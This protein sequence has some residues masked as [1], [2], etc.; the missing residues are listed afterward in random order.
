MNEEA[1]KTRTE[2]LL[3]QLNDDFGPNDGSNF[4]LMG[5]LRDEQEQLDPPAPAP[6]EPVEAPEAPKED[7]ELAYHALNSSIQDLKRT[8]QQ[9][10]D[11]QSQV[12]Q[13]LSR[14]QQTTP[15]ENYD[16]TQLASYGDLM[17]IR[18]QLSQQQ[19]QLAQQQ[20]QLAAQTAWERAN[21][22]YER[23]ASKHGDFS[24]HMN[25]EQ[26]GQVFS[27]TYKS[28]PQTI[29]TADWDTYLS[30][31]YNA[32]QGGKAKE[33][34]SEIDRLNKELLKYRGQAK[35][36]SQA[37][38]QLIPRSTIS[39]PAA[40]SSNSSNTFF[41]HIERLPSFKSVKRGGGDMQT[42]GRQLLTTLSQGA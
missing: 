13:L 23:M 30:H 12:E 7:E 4:G 15:Q 14:Q 28:N 29:L 11:R 32:T 17:N 21:G 22:A 9:S 34:A 5:I 20:Q 25:R 38:T 19:Q 1:P 37:N 24:K 6:E 41:Q 3:E 26:F 10:T 8:V 18:N 36:T 31:S 2:Q 40:S 42:F 27:N 35:Q 33:L 39:N 16:P